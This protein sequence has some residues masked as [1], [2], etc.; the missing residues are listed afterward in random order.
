MKDRPKKRTGLPHS[1]FETHGPTRYLI[2]L[3]PR[4]NTLISAVLREWLSASV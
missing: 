2:I 4:L 3:T 1:Y